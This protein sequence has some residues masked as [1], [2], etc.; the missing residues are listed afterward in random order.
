MRKSC[1][2]RVFL[3]GMAGPDLPCDLSPAGGIFDVQLLPELCSEGVH[4][5]PAHTSDSSAISYSCDG[6]Y[7]YAPLDV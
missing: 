3:P 1:T 4:P 6:G 2:L 5:L 7:T